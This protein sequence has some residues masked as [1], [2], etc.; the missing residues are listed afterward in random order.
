MMNGLSV[1]KESVT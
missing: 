1:V